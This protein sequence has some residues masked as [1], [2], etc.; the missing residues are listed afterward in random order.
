[1]AGR[2]GGSYFSLYPPC[3]ACGRHLG[4]VHCMNKLKKKNLI[5][6]NSSTGVENSIMNPNVPI[7]QLQ[8]LAVKPPC[9]I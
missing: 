8:P 5:M 3:L 6:E 2:G 7:T 4:N 1:M 9:H